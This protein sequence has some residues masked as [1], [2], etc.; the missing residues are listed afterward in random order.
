MSGTSCVDT[1]VL[2]VPIVSCLAINVVLQL[3]L[4]LDPMRRS[5]CLLLGWRIDGMIAAL[6]HPL[7]LGLRYPYGKPPHKCRILWLIS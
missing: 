3:V 5:E 6:A 7:A 1:V 4:L 2:C